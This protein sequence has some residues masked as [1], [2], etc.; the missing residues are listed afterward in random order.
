MTRKLFALGWLIFV[1]CSPQD[2]TDSA[3]TLETGSDYP[4]YGGNNANNRYSPLTQINAGNVND[5]QV[6]WTYFANDKP[7]STGKPS[8][9]RE[10]QCQPIVVNGILYAT[11]AELNLFA[12]KADTGEQLWKFEPKNKQPLRSNRGVMYWSREEDE[13][14][15]YTA[16]SYLYAVDAL[17]GE[18]ITTFGEQGAVDLHVGP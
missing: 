12:L 10:I 17:T 8:N 15:Y 18:S 14:I 11:S 9:P 6:A 4:A 2:L 13:R 16:G 5:L 1:G 7:D 3:V